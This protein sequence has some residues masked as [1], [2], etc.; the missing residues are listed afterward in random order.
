MDALIQNPK[1]L[2]SP[3]SWLLL[4]LHHDKQHCAKLPAVPSTDLIVSPSM[5]AQRAPFRTA[6]CWLGAWARKSPGHLRIARGVV[7]WTYGKFATQQ[8]Q[9]DDHLVPARKR[10]E[11]SVGLPDLL[12]AILAGALRVR[13]CAHFPEMKACKYLI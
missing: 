1:V 3:G 4:P 12:E 5:E 10:G 8:R 9:Q 6:S 13:T 11:V 2:E 7:N